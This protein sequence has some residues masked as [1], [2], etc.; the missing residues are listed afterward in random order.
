M[1]YPIG[2][3]RIIFFSDVEVTIAQVSFIAYIRQQVN[4]AAY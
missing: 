2:T 4:I 3:I 1:K